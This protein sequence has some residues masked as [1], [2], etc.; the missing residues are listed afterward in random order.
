MSETRT[1]PLLTSLICAVGL[2]VGAAALGRSL[3]AT[4]EG[5]PA[6]PRNVP[7]TSLPPFLA[8]PFEL[9]FGGRSGGYGAFGAVP[10]RAILAAVVA[11]GA[12]VVLVV[13]VALLRDDG[14]H[15]T[16]APAH[17]DARPRYEA[18]DADRPFGPATTDVD[19]AWLAF[20]RS[21]DLD[22]PRRRTPTELEDAASE[23]RLDA[24][25]VR[26]LRT[27]AEAVYYRGDSPGR[28]ERRV[29][30]AA[31][32]LGLGPGREDRNEED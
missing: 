28:Y 1:F 24:D 23:R 15:P 9:L 3:P 16:G 30:E 27:A 19:R 26:E 32:T 20:V 21:L 17:H 6:T 11:A 12:L 22:R 10:V 25:A 7:E 29:R 4:V 8:R 18:D 5:P 13:L 14:A 2:A 31:R